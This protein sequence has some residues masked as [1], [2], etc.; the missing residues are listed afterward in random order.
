[1]EKTYDDAQWNG[2]CSLKKK[3]QRVCQF[4]LI[5]NIKIFD[6]GNKKL[7]QKK[8]LV[9]DSV[10]FRS[11]ENLYISQPPKMGKNI[12]GLLNEIFL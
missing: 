5:L 10:I 11:R 2:D 1:M 4:R 6:I 8:I 3:V 12:R 9:H 7:R